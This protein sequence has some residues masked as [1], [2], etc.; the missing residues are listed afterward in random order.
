MIKTYYRPTSLD[1][2]LSLLSNPEEKAKPLGGGT[3]ISKHKGPEISVVDL[4]ELGLNNIEKS[5]GRISAGAMVRLDA[6]LKNIDIHEELKRAIRLDTHENSRNM[7][8]LGGWLVSSHGRSTFSTLLM[9]LDATLTW[10]PGGT[11]VR[12]GDW[13]PTRNFESPGLLI[14]EITWWSQPKLV[15][16]YV[17]RSPKDVPIL[18]VAVAQWGSGRTRITLGGFGEAPNLAMDGP[19]ADGAEI[20]CRD[21]CSDAD[22]QWA[23]AVYRRE[24]ASKLAKRCL[25]RINAQSESEV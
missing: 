15:F 3:R 19:D 13:L 1:E 11:K 6:L 10:A 17:A 7:A 5:G 4:Q 9:A 24:V 22:D 2:A 16:E 23:S 20:A 8:T 12:L 21:A 14:T 18:I 25:T